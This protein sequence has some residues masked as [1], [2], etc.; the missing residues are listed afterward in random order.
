MTQIQD[1][2][3]A[4][5]RPFDPRKTDIGACIDNLVFYHL[6]SAVDYL[7]SQGFSRQA[8]EKYIKTLPCQSISHDPTEYAQRIGARTYVSVVRPVR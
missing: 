6:D 5:L 8:A 2:C 1:H 3:I 7:R 4:Y